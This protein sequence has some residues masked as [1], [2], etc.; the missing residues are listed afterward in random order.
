MA[1][2]WSEKPKGERWA[3]IG[4][5]AAAFI[6]VPFIMDLGTVGVFVGVGIASLVGWG[7]GLLAAVAT[8]GD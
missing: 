4:A 7:A 6:S 1:T 8:G 2:K 3:M 5:I